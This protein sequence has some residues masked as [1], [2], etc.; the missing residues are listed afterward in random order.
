MATRMGG[1]AVEHPDTAVM[2]MNAPQTSATRG[3]IP[4]ALASMVA[5]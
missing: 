2:A 1:S 3:V 5:P 4:G